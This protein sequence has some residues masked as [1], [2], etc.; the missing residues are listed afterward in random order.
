MSALGQKQTFV[1]GRRVRFASECR[2]SPVQV[3]CPKSATS[4]LDRLISWLLIFCVDRA[5]R[6]EER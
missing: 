6:L 1:G 5:M 3:E 4:G 2:H